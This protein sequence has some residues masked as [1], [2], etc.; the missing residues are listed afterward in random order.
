MA[1]RSYYEILGVERTAD[2]ETIRRAYLTIARANHPDKRAG[3]GVQRSD[4]ESKIRDAN[5]AWNVLGVD[6]KR[7][8]YDRTLPDEVRRAAPRPTTPNLHDRRPQPPS[9]IVVP[10]HTA[11]LW[12]WGPILVA[13]IIGAV[14]I[15][16]SAYA[17]S[18]D[19]ATPSSTP[20]TVSTQYVPGSCVV[21]L[22]GSGGKIAQSVG[23][24]QQYAS[25]VSS[26]VD[27]PRPCPPQTVA[28]PLADGKT[29]LCLVGAQ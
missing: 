23:C 1:E 3:Q 14:L 5:A 28:V 7:R 29:T 17:T 2:R 8:E 27:S 6:S 22:A 9:G 21:I 11:S 26:Q 13:V 24:D 16:G 15:I 18:H 12:K 4:A 20:S 10:A 25:I 19:S